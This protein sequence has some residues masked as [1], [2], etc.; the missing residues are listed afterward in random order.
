M[1]KLL[2][3]V[4]QVFTNSKF[5]LFFMNFWSIIKLEAFIFIIFSTKD[6]RINIIL[7]LGFFR[8]N[9]LIFDHLLLSLL[10]SLI[11]YVDLNFLLSKSVP[12]FFSSALLIHIEHICIFLFFVETNVI[13]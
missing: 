7:P 3:E 12:L 5:I 2:L 8:L 4:K 6:L 10:L 11:S 13:S 9:L 1:A